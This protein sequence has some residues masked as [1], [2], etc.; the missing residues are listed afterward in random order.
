MQESKI[1]FDEDPEFKKRAYNCVVSLQNYES[2]IMKAWKLICDAS[3][4]GK[5]FR[6]PINK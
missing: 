1:R 5:S 6:K 4:K 3:M 2:D